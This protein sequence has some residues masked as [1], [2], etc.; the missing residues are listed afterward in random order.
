[1]VAQTEL[2][3]RVNEALRHSDASWGF[4]RML[5]HETSDYFDILIVAEKH[6][7]G[8]QPGTRWNRFQQ[9]HRAKHQFT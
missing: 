8:M 1:M 6:P 5:D 7:L 3:I 4:Y 9:L 2:K